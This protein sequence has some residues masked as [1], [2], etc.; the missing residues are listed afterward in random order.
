MSCNKENYRFFIRTMMLNNYTASDIHR[1]LHQ[2]WGDECPNIRTVYRVMSDFE[3]GERKSV[4]DA[5]RSGRPRTSVTAANV[6]AV[7]ELV[8]ENNRVSIHC[9]HQQ[10]GLSEGSIFTILHDELHLK[11]LCDKWIPKELTADQKASRVTVAQSLLELFNSGFPPSHIIYTDEKWFYLRSIGTKQGNKVWVGSAT[12]K[13]GIPRRSQFDRKCHVVFAATFGG[14][15]YYE[16]VP[17][18][19]SV[20]SVY[21]VQFL[22]NMHQ[23]FAHQSQHIGW[24]NSCLIH[25]NAR[26][27]VAKLVTAFVQKKGMTVRCQAPYSPDFNLED[28]WLFSRLENM[29]ANTNFEDSDD[30]NQFLSE[31]MQSIPKSEFTKAFEKLKTNFAA[32]INA[33][34]SYI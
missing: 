29:R 16:I 5:T 11:S 21:Y 25:D 15:F 24:R 20:D 28:A 27:H 12:E 18:N 8:E 7:R 9:L 26:P 13:P 2:A 14:S 6:E 31:A 23:K 17:R 1:L 4:E 32:V 30:L 3:S 19:A 33:N 10:L 22:T 34:G